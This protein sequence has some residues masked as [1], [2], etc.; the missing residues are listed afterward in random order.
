LLCN[1]ARPAPPEQCD[2][3]IKKAIDYLYSQQKDG[4]WEVKGELQG[5][6]GNM[7]SNGMHYGGPTAIA[8]YAML[9]AGESAQDPKLQKAIEFL[10]KLQ[11]QSAY[12]IGCR[13]QIWRY[14][15]RTPETQQLLKRDIQL[16][17][18]QIKATGEAR[19][20]FHYPIT[21]PEEYDHSVSQFGVLGLFS[22]Q[23]AGGE[24]ATQVWDAMDI[25][26]RRHQEPSGAWAYITGA[27]DH[28]GEPTL[29]M[30]AAGVASLFITHDYVHAGKSRGTSGNAQDDNIE[31]GL[32]WIGDN[33]ENLLNE[34]NIGV[35]TYTLYALERIGVTAGY[36]YFGSTNWFEF[37]SDL[38]L[39]T[40]DR[41]GSWSSWRDWSDMNIN[42]VPTTSFGILFLVHGR[43]PVAINKLRYTSSAKNARPD[44]NQRPRDVAN[45][46]RWSA[47]QAETL[48]N[49]HIVPLD[50]PLA[51]WHDAPILYLSGS[52]AVELPDDAKNKLRAF[53]EEGGMIVVHVDG[54]AKPFAVS[55][56]KLF[57]SIFP[58]YEFRT[59][60]ENH[61]IFT[62]Q[63]F[64]SDVL[65][66]LP[67]LLGLSNGVRELVVMIPD[68]DP[69]RAW[70]V[71]FAGSTSAYGFGANLIHYASDQTILH[72][73]VSPHIVQVDDKIATTR[74]I[75]LARLQH[76]GNWDPEPGGWKRMRAILHNS[77]KIDLQVESLKLG[78]GKLTPD[79]FPIAHLTGT[80]KLSLSDT[81]SNELKS[82][83]QSGGRLL[84]DA[85]G[86][87]AV[88][89][90][91]AEEALRKILPTE[92]AQLD[93]PL[94]ADN[95]IYPKNIAGKMLYRRFATQSVGAM[96]APRLRAIKLKDRLAIVYSRE[97]LSAGM[98]GQQVDGINGYTPEVATEISRAVLLFPK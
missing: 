36:R 48:L 85:A 27:K 69:A 97:D 86:G 45:L 37:G 73:R 88:F 20:L 65:K 14:L 51:E 34:R 26:W 95:V 74:S 83:A 68:G 4:L 59:L 15:P 19:G 67:K 70:Q 56:T 6:A 38:L 78:E 28:L 29:S 11:T 5:V 52:R 33:I 43:A 12:V 91:S 61:P 75:K 32:R 35:V 13:A 90:E 2:A 98:V 77:D 72:E 96:T 18:R 10:K 7:D 42:A 84:I 94:P 30:T 47:T 89:A 9:A 8:T 22:C 3:S 23:E 55:I 64:K 16:L 31:R 76:N 44:W 63:Q 25:A 80:G 79:A 57:S 93:E 58:A 41:S 60:P 62:R 46:V 21:R 49:W 71:P 81:Q 92:S 1:I 87:N 17:A 53:V 40:Q 50:A 66:P 24:V 54:G 39:R 82:F